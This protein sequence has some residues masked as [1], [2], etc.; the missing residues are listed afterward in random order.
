MQ[1]DLMLERRLVWDS[2]MV[3]AIRSPRHICYGCLRFDQYLTKNL[4]C[5]RQVPEVICKLIVADR[6]KE[7]LD[8][9]MFWKCH[10][11]G[12]YHNSEALNAGLG[13]LMVVQSLL[14]V[15]MPLKSVHTAIWTMT[16]IH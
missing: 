12:C 10:N 8:F 1:L 13:V 15:R 9:S 14:I 3:V 7:W 6:Q 16:D 5:L 11:R 2:S 4:H